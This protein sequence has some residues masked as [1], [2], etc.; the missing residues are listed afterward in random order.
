MKVAAPL[1]LLG[2]GL[3]FA[4]LQLLSTFTLAQEQEGALT[5]TDK[6]GLTVEVGVEA[7]VQGVTAHSAFWGLGDTFGTGASY[8]ANPTWLESYMKPYLT[9]GANVGNTDVYGKASAIASTTGGVDVFGQ[10]HASP[11]QVEDAFIGLRVGGLDIS[12]GS[13]PYQL[14]T[15]ML[16]ADGGA[17]G[18]ERGALIFG[19]RTAWEMA[20][21]GRL[22]VA[23]P[24]GGGGLSCKRT[25]ALSGWT[26]RTSKRLTI[27]PTVSREW[28]GGG[29]QGEFPGR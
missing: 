14:G 29:L 25:R 6:G 8:N 18:F 20:A 3:S 23:R 4:C 27:R 19:P 17:D 28:V 11:I 7:G 10:G 13:Q 1:R 5:L 15:G 12:A 26:L 16:L 24:A 22:P 21:I 9:F 2:G